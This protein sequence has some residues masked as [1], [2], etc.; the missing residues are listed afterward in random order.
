VDFTL[1]YDGSLPSTG[2]PQQKHELRVAFHPQL[3][4][5]WEQPG[6]GQNADAAPIAEIGGR[7]FRALVHPQWNFRA[8]LDIT[9]LRPEDPGGV[10]IKGDIDNRLKTLFDG[11]TRP[12][13]AQEFPSN[14]LPEAGQ[15]PLICLL[16]DDSLIKAVNVRTDRLLAPA[17]P[18]HVKLIIRVSVRTSVSFGGL[19]MWG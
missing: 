6:I 1:T 17:N 13:H 15:D 5:L 2:R 3:A 9:M 16:D 19:A 14:W 11:L 8:D 4:D 10:I 12:H 7:R 18:S